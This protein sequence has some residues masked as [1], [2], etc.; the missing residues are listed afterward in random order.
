MSQKSDDAAEKILLRERRRFPD[1]EVDFRTGDE[2]LDD[3]LDIVVAWKDAG[4]WTLCHGRRGRLGARRGAAFRFW[5]R[6]EFP[7]HQNVTGQACGGLEWMPVWIT[8]PED[9]DGNLVA[10]GTVTAAALGD[11]DNDGADPRGNGSS[12]RVEMRLSSA[13]VEALIFQATTKSSTAP[14]RTTC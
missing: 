2:G 6:V 8:L 9:M 1:S 4:M 5:H 7:S 14:T 3:M 10:D 11:I 12:A 13:R